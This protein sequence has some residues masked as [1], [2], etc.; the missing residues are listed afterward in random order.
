MTLSSAIK[1]F[2]LLNGASPTV[3]LENNELYIADMEA[4]RLMPIV[5][6]NMEVDGN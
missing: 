2:S 3:V 4:P 6:Q 5:S 1:K